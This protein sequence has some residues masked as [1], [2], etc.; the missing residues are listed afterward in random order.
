MANEWDDRLDRIGRH[1]LRAKFR[2]R[3][4]D[5]TMVDLRGITTVRK[6]S[7]DLIGRRPTPAEPYDD[8]RQT[9]Y[10]GH[11]VF[12]ARH[13]TATCRRTCLARPAPYPRRPPAA[14]TMPRPHRRPKGEGAGGKFCHQAC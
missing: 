11:P 14:V 5:R 1:P 13:A 9:P 4:R 3:G 7:G 6:H 10:R 8:G 12:V 2:L